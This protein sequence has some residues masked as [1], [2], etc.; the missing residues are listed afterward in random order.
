L[1]TINYEDT[2]RRNGLGR[3]MRAPGYYLESNSGEY[4][5]LEDFDNGE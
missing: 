1:Q 5:D 4:E 2:Q 3:C